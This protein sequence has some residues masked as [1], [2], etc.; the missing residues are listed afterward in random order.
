MKMTKLFTATLL[1]GALFIGLTGVAQNKMMKQDT[2]MVG[3]A[4]MFPT[5][6]S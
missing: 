2:K 1:F 5:K 4:E 3:G 6:I